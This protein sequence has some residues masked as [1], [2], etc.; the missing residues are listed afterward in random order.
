MAASCGARVPPA[1]AG[2]EADA[3]LQDMSRFPFAAPVAVTFAT[4]PSGT[5][6]RLL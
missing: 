2:P 6:F 3:L 4:S 5:V 1:G